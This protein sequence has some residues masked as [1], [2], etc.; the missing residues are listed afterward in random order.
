[1]HLQSLRDAHLL[2]DQTPDLPGRLHE[3]SDVGLNKLIELFYLA[4]KG[5]RWLRLRDGQNSCL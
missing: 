4:R 2:L 5:L 3:G 1:M